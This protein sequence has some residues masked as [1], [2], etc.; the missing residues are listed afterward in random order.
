MPFGGA[1]YPG[2][3]QSDQQSDINQR[4]HSAKSRGLQQMSQ[5]PREQP[6][7]TMPNSPPAMYQSNPRS[8]K[9]PPSSKAANFAD[10]RQEEW[11]S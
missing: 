7:D 6:E 9:R 1:E 10:P 4:V 5:D 8:N 11:N 3:P 2:A